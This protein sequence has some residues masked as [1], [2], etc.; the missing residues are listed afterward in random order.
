MDNKKR[1]KALIMLGISMIS[2]SGC[3]SKDT[4]NKY[5][6]IK[7]YNIDSN[8]ESNYYLV[9]V[10]NEFIKNNKLRIIGSFETMDDARKYLDS[11]N[12]EEEKNFGID[13]IIGIILVGGFYYWCIRSYTSDIKKEKSKILKK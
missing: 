9:K 4:T 12:S 11:L 6:I 7:E 5:K 10:E 8:D 2:L 3:S 1:I 13:D